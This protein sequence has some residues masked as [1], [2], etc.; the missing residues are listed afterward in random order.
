MNDRNAPSGVSL[1]VVALLSAAA[2]VALGVGAV[3]FL[4]ASPLEPRVLVVGLVL[5]GSVAALVGYAARRAGRTET[6][7]WGS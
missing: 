3:G 7:Y 5:L 6:P 4:L 2:V 1:R